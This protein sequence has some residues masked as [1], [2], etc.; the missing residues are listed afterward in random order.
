MANKLMIAALMLAAGS[1]TFAVNNNDKINI[2]IDGALSRSFKVGDIKG[3]SYENPRDNGF[4]KIRF[5][6]SDS[7]FQSL[8]ISKIESMEYVEGLAD[9]PYTFTVTPHHMCASLQIAGPGENTWYRLSG[10][11]VKK[12][13]GIDK[14]L[15]PQILV[16]A[17]IDYLHS[18]ADYY[19]YPL[20]HWEMSEIFLNDVGQIDWFPDEVIPAGQEIAVCLYTA[21]I[22]NDEVEVTSEPYMVVFKCKEIEDVGTKFDISADMT[23]TKINV[24]VDPINDPDIQYYFTIYSAEDIASTGLVRLIEM[25]LLN[26][27]KQIYQYGTAGGWDDVLY[28]GHAERTW[29]N[30]CSGE[31]YVAVAFG[32]EYGVTTTDASWQAFEIPLAVPTDDCTFTV[33]QEQ[34]SAA[35][36]KINVVPSKPDTRYA[37]YLVKSEKIAEDPENPDQHK[38]EYWLANQINFSVQS[39]TINWANNPK[40]YTGEKTLSTKDDIFDGMLLQAGVEYTVLLFG[41]NTDGERTTELVKIPV[42]TQEAEVEEPLTFTIEFGEMDMSSP[43]FR[44]LPIKITPSDPTKTYVFDKLRMSNSYANINNCSDTEFMN[45]FAASY[46]KYLT[47]YTGEKE[48]EVMMSRDNTWEDYCIFIYGYEGAPTG[49]LYYYKVDPGTATIQQLRGPGIE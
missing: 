38:A 43:Y 23:S 5:D 41:V 7:E 42:C 24:K 31:V 40:I 12:L 32:V 44:G 4:S 13:E 30:R 33:T 11:P 15:W 35:E 27:E 8:P 18:V 9:N 49:P 48:T 16:Q 6:F 36:V 29:K 25:T 1:S 46:G 47:V 17:D 10:V 39:N 2:T 19:Q 37:A 28:R 22:V 26:L 34:V 21:E 45:R 20:S 14:S 3:I